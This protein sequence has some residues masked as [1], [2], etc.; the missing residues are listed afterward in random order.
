MREVRL[1]ALH[2]LVA[3][4]RRAGFVIF[5]AAVPVLAVLG[6]AAVLVFQAVNRD[7]PPEQVEVG[8]VDLTSGGPDGG[9]LF[10]AFRTQGTVTFVPYPDA[11]AGTAALLA[12]EV[13][14]LYL[15]PTDYLATGT[16][17]ELRPDRPGVPLDEGG[18]NP[19]TTPLGRFLLNNLFVG[20]VSLDR[21]GRV[22]QPYA[23]ARVTVDETGTPISD[24]NP[25]EGLV[26]FLALGTLLMVA[27]FTTSGYLLQGLS[28][29]KEGRI[30][31]V[32]LSCVRPEQLFAGKLLG[33]GAA[34]AVQVAVWLLSAVGFVAVL[35]RMDGV[36]AG[37][38]DV[39]GPLPVLA[40][41]V[42]FL[43]GYALFGTLM[44]AL[45]AV[46]TTQR[47]SGQVTAIIILPA[48]VPYWML[49]TLLENPD[50]ALARVLSIIPHTAPLT[51]MV[52]LGTGAM[53]AVDLVVGL[54]VM[55]GAVALVVAGTLRLF[56]VYLLAMGTRPGLSAMLRTLV[57]GEP[58]PAAGAGRGR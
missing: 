33:L 49:P 32:L 1:I 34:G 42:Y 44:A 38:F 41:S 12:G 17:V 54:A 56:R 15:I 22:L 25:L 51:A 52:R 11:E 13:E 24:A 40:A 28:E 45:G 23:L 48:M 46:T 14:A 21:V 3:T 50:G 31:E 53:N 55:A 47:E 43:L 35:S 37:L 10:I 20:E 58:S 9:G 7:R 39:P 27:M 16:V 4:L 36:P 5:T 19:N 18:S 29:E 30:M 8:Y 2:E 6:L 57:R 26:F